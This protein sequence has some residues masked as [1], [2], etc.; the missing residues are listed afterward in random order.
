MFGQSA[1]FEASK[2]KYYP[3]P[4]SYTPDLQFSD[5]L[6]SRRPAT[7]QLPKPGFNRYNYITNNLLGEVMVLRAGQNTRLG[8]GS[9]PGAAMVN[10]LAKKSHNILALD[11]MRKRSRLLAPETPMEPPPKPVKQPRPE[12][13]SLMRRAQHLLA[14]IKGAQ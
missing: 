10:P 3:G 1:R 5:L 6:P 2:S 9:Y 14:N 12:A 13:V 8:P 4:G 11:S 7:A